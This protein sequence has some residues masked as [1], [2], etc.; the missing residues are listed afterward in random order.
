MDVKKEYES[1]V[2][3]DC[4][5]S[6]SDSRKKKGKERVGDEMTMCGEEEEKAGDV[7]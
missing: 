3:V 6:D 1:D 4:S 5:D 2:V 7:S